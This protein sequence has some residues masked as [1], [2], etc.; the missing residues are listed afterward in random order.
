MP[1]R[2]LPWTKDG[3]SPGSAVQV[4]LSLRPLPAR[5]LSSCGSPAA[6]V[7]GRWPRTIARRRK[8]GWVVVM[9]SLGGGCSCLHRTAWLDE[10]DPLGGSVAI[11]LFPRH[12]LTLSSTFVPLVQ[13]LLGR[14]ACTDDPFPRDDG[15]PH[16]TRA[17]WIFNVR[18]WDGWFRGHIWS[19][20][21]IGMRVRHRMKWIPCDG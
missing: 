16:E 10:N 7:P 4:E 18:S 19:S 13:V 14:W 5:G 17:K 1:G 12:M 3:A 9:V 2:S 6:P 21:P 11:A 8:A 15:G 20:E